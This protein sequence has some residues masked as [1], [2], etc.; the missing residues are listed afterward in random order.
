MSEEEK[1]LKDGDENSDDTGQSDKKN[2]AD[3]S[4]KDEKV[5]ISKSELEK[6]QRD[7]DN[8]REATLAAKRKGRT[9]PGSEPIKEK[10]KEDVDDDELTEEF[11][12]KKDFLKGIEKSAIK[13]ASK[14]PEVD[15]NWDAIM[16]FYNSRHGKETVE[17]ILA[18]IEVAHKTWK[19][20]HPS[21]DKPKEDDTDKKVKSE[22]AKDSGLGKG[23]DKESKPERKSIIPKQEKM[24]DWYGDKK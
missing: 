19:S 23:K 13:E 21:T 5:E 12:T 22:L 4:D 15:E 20:M 24:E 3:S 1:D 16:E 6:I 7:R 2:N 18:D 14:N 8:Y 11:I 17:D 10:E 9:I